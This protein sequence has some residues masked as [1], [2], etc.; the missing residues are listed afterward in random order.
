MADNGND[1]NENNEQNGK[2]NAPSEQK[3]Q[4]N[5]FSE[6]YADEIEN[7]LIGINNSFS[8]LSRGMGNATAGNNQQ[9]GP[10]NLDK[11]LAPR[12]N[13]TANLTK[14][15]SDLSGM[16]AMEEPKEGEDKKEAPE[17][18]MNDLSIPAGAMENSKKEDGAQAAV[19][20]DKAAMEANNDVQETAQDQ[21]Q[22]LSHAGASAPKDSG[23]MVDN[24]AA[25]SSIVAKIMGEYKEKIET[26][27][28][29]ELK[30]SQEAGEESND[31]PPASDLVN[32]EEDP[33]AMEGGGTNNNTG[34][35]GAGMDNP[36]GND[37]AG[38]EETTAN[39]TDTDTTSSE[40]VVG[41]TQNQDATQEGG[42]SAQSDDALSDFDV[43][44]S[45]EQQ[46]YDQQVQQNNAERERAKNKGLDVGRSVGYGAKITSGGENVEAFGNDEASA[47]QELN[48]YRDQQTAAAQN[49][50][51]VYYG[52]Y[53][54]GYNEGIN[55][56]VRLKREADAA[57]REKALNAEQSTIEFKVGAIL[58]MACGAAA[59]KGQ[60]DIDTSYDLP[61][62]EGGAEKV[63]IKGAMSPVRSA[64]MSEKKT[65]D[66]RL[67]GESLGRAFIQHYNMAQQEASRQKAAGPEKDADYQAG[68]ERGYTLGGQISGGGAGDEALLKERSE[69]GN[70]DENTPKPEK[71]QKI[72]FA[73][74]YNKALSD[75]QKAKQDERKKEIEDRNNDP[76]FMAGFAT[77]SMQGFLKAILAPSGITVEA[78]L[79]DAK[80]MQEGGIPE[81]FPIPDAI[82][83]N[84]KGVL[85]TG[86]DANVQTLV[87]KPKFKQGLL[88]GFNKGYMNGEQNR[89]S[90]KREQFKLH[91][92]YQ[93][94]LKVVYTG[95]DGEGRTMGGLKAML[96]AER[97]DLQ[98]QETL[99][100]DDQGKLETYNKTLAG[101][102][103]E[104][105]KQSEYY[106][107]GVVVEY[108][109][110]IAVEEKKRKDKAI[111]AIL[112]DKEYVAGKE[113][114]ELVGAKIFE[115]KNRLKEYHRNG[116]DVSKKNA[117]L[118]KALNNARLEA[119][120]Q[121]NKYF[122]GYARGYSDTLREKEKKANE[123]DIGNKLTDEQTGKAVE[124]ITKEG[125]GTLKL[126]DFF[127]LIG[128]NN[129]NFS[130]RDLDR[131]N[132]AAGDKN[133]AQEAF[134]QGAAQGY[135]LFYEN[136]MEPDK[137]FESLYT[138]QVTD[139]AGSNPTATERL[140]EAYFFMRGFAYNGSAS[141]GAPKGK[142]DAE[143]YR[144]GYEDAKRAAENAGSEDT[145]TPTREGSA[146]SRDAYKS[147]FNAGKRAEQYQNFRSRMMQAQ[148]VGTVAGVTNTDHT[149][150]AATQNSLA[151]T[152]A[153]GAL[154][155]REEEDKVADAQ[156]ADQSK[157]DTEG[158]LQEYEVNPAEHELVAKQ[159]TANTQWITKVLYLK[160]G[161]NLQGTGLG[162]TTVSI[163][164]LDDDGKPVTKTIS[165]K[166]GDLLIAREFYANKEQYIEQMADN[167][168]KKVISDNEQLKK[169]LGVAEKLAEAGNQSEISSFN[170]KLAPI[171]TAYIKG[172]TD[173]LSQLESEVAPM[174]LK[175]WQHDVGYIEALKQQAGELAPVQE[176]EIPEGPYAAKDIP[177]DDSEGYKE[178]NLEGLVMG[179]RLKSGLA[180]LEGDSM[181]NAQ[182]NA[183]QSGF[184]DGK[185][186]GIKTAELAAKDI[187]KK[188]PNEADIKKK[189][190][191]QMKALHQEVDAEYERG[192]I[193]GF[194]EDYWK[195]RD[196][197]YGRH[198]GFKRSTGNATDNEHYDPYGVIEAEEGVEIKDQE[199]FFNGFAKGRENGLAGR[200]EQSTG[201]EGEAKTSFEAK[202]KDV[203]TEVAEL[204]A[205]VRAAKE[206]KV[207]S[208]LPFV[209]DSKNERYSVF[210]ENKFIKLLNTG[211]GG[212]ADSNNIGGELSEAAVMGY[213]LPET[214]E[215]ETVEQVLELPQVLAVLNELFGTGEQQ[216]GD[217]KAPQE[218]PEQ[219]ATRELR[220]ERLKLRYATD[221]KTMYDTRKEA[222]YQQAL[223][224]MNNLAMMAA[225]DTGS[226]SSVGMGG[227][228][229]EQ[230]TIEDLIEQIEELFANG[231]HQNFII[232]DLDLIDRF[233]ELEDEIESHNYPISK[234]LEEVESY[235]LAMEFYTDAGT[236]LAEAEIEQ[237][238]ADIKELKA[239]KKGATTAEK[240]D[241]SNEIRVLEQSLRDKKTGKRQSKSEQDKL[242][243]EW[244]KAEA[245]VKKEIDT[246]RVYM[247]DNLKFDTPLVSNDDILEYIKVN[248]ET[249]KEQAKEEKVY[250]DPEIFNNLVLGGAFTYKEGGAFDAYVQGDGRLTID[251]EA[252]KMRAEGVE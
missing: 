74:G 99:S 247:K 65:P 124:G 48:A 217:S 204:N 67:E 163:N 108:N 31:T 117:K 213:A 187:K 211:G 45:E 221:F 171:K 176:L 1:P 248:L 78:A 13:R 249:S 244:E 242:Q 236:T 76:I 180:T 134:K 136:K 137:P 36:S 229:N 159:N 178:G 164:V 219:K 62:E 87:A 47:L 122:R 40:T 186:I 115:T 44:S 190:D 162:D 189:V 237:L 160:D 59:A 49:E 55:E 61:K 193:A 251:A 37:T 14:N 184:A 64:V 72:G 155:E 21:E 250:Q 181:A 101:L 19:G 96:K 238:Q 154:K 177:R 182:G 92:D 175:E 51:D 17:P 69:L 148:P 4:G 174:A 106:Q 222:S 198:V 97:D 8:D 220:E 52:A 102:D 33:R 144:I 3:K 210:A 158:N 84:L 245:E 241:I 232:D 127:K 30:A 86:G 209:F 215:I 105:S 82:R 110:A 192:Y 20:N 216:E 135:N 138:K 11:E 214:Q 230:G 5:L 126:D 129:S 56:G 132:E 112:N 150:H 18:D 73:A 153:L 147:G 104:V 231:S 63:E 200:E 167:H 151:D 89:M 185:A 111:A 103:A 207:V 152:S 123:S 226:G 10:E 113:R 128:I 107:R 118:N 234:K 79:N 91:P 60:T 225:M 156:L 235:K 70:R 243:R 168:L 179:Q 50:G 139:K 81:F 46:Q 29:Q 32:N 201:K 28:E 197:T 133:K 195:V 25:N 203:V 98:R 199:A 6:S 194:F 140:A 143:S 196:F 121:G 26:V 43:V 53:A 141:Y 227:G 75:A 188:P 42:E 114:G 202:M 206:M 173:L 172:Y 170:R 2:I 57:Q 120:K 38:N 166:P 68:Y 77:G 24:T 22:D 39:N 252:E 125:A 16:G 149:Q 109:K 94:S 205:A 35:D 83:N 183:Y 142:G 85:G 15:T 169:Q 80:L 88:M 71:Q 34:G 239:K 233:Y 130:S 208:K 54:Q 246:I 41:G 23:A 95:S 116:I 157:K 218:T 58:G 7:G 224:D 191:E 146:S 212:V 90:F 223:V 100:D 161:L 131:L 240:K 9:M 145:T 228:N 12:T 27:K 165:N 66:G 119:K 93:E